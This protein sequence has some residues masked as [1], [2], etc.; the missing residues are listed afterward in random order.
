MKAEEKKWTWPMD[1]KAGLNRIEHQIN[2]AAT[3]ITA[4]LVVFKAYLRLAP[5]V[6]QMG[7]DIQQPAGAIESPGLGPL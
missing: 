7:N 4:G 6:A 3:S 2:D 5:T 1:T